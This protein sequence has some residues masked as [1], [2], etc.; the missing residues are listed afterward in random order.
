[1]TD[2]NDL[3]G[4]LLTAPVGLRGRLK[5]TPILN[6]KTVRTVALRIRVYTEAGLPVVDV[7]TTDGEVTV[8]EIPR[9]AAPFKPAHLERRP[10]SFWFYGAGVEVGFLADQNAGALKEPM[11]VEQPRK[12]PQPP[13]Q[14]TEGST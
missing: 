9:A 3:P 8:V 4:V 6:R 13:P 14:A 5:V 1:M 2:P 10:G 7:R 11:A 12:G